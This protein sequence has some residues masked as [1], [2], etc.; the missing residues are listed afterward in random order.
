MFTGMST[1]PASGYRQVIIFYRVV[2]LRRVKLAEFLQQ[3]DVIIRFPSVTR[4]QGGSG[5]WQAV[6]SQ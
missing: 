4:Q 1:S 2:I 6:V 3:V 5:P